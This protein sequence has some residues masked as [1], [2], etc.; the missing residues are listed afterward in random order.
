MPP[1]ALFHQVAFHRQ[2]SWRGASTATPMAP[3]AVTTTRPGRTVR[4]STVEIQAP[5][6][7][8]T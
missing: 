3:G 8:A 2:T 7:Q 5:P 4:A 1:S 6:A